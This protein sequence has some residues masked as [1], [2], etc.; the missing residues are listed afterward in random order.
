MNGFRQHAQ[1]AS[2]QLAAFAS[3]LKPA[4][5]AAA[6]L[7]R[8]KLCVLD[9]AACAIHA[10]T[11]PWGKILG[12][13]AEEQGGNPQAHLWGR[14]ARVPAAMAAL[15]NGTLVHSFELDDLHKASILHPSSAAVPAALAVAESRGGIAGKDLLTAC[16]AGFEVGA[17]AGM[18]V[19]TSHL[20]RGFHPT[21]T[22]G[23]V[24]AA[25]AAG[26][27]LG[28]DAAQME[29]AISIGA[30]Q[31]AGLMAAQ[32]ESMVKRMHA[33]RASQSGVYGA[34]LAARGFTGINNVFEVNYGGYCSTLSDDPKPELIDKGLGTVFETEKVGFKVYSC[35]GS[36]HTS[37]EAARRIVA[38][39]PVA[40][41]AIE[42]IRVLCSQATLLHVGWPYEPRSVTAAQMNLPYCLAVTLIDG[43]AFVEQFT[44]DR[45]GRN[46]VI[47]L[48]GRV[49]VKRDLEFD[50]L[51]PAGRHK[52]T[53]SIELRDGTRIDET[54][55]H[56]KGSD[57][58]PLTDDEVIAKFYRLVTPI[59][60]EAWA[61]KARKTIMSLDTARDTAALSGL[62]AE[63]PR[64][65][66][67][68]SRVKVHA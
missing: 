52:V 65:T 16:V 59:H 31:A 37:V 29:H 17:R 36:C 10:T 54:V 18:S 6:A 20:V 19:G 58:D 48:A 33:G 40:P 42:K 22:N 9:A 53:V 15:V 32:F 46:D 60:G 12:D 62:L 45:I 50:A 21:G 49:D 7:E 51:G 5:V 3:A 27:V 47:A 68:E 4:A 14:P 57:Q 24:A 1:G 2:A 30:T 55:S 67:S 61:D 26:H 23:A 11:L 56:A 25:A 8:M 34:E 66:T 39:R 63:S 13:Y 44:P 64:K 41:D 35:C 28:L 38:R 43:D